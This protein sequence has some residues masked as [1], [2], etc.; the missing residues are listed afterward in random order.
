MLGS[1]PY[2]LGESMRKIVLTLVFGLL[3]SGAACSASDPPAPA[4][5]GVDAGTPCDPGTL[6]CI[7]IPGGTGCK[8]DLLCVAGR[9]QET[10]VEGPNEPDPTPPSRP[11]PPRP[12]S[13]SPDDAG[14]GAP[15]A[16]AAAASDPPDASSPG[17]TP[18]VDAGAEPEDASAD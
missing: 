18:V 8:D 9:C 2:P 14:N 5:V 7:C 15:G 17:P 10:E 4:D 3:G 11:R 12:G 1:Y 13:N 16:D 6:A